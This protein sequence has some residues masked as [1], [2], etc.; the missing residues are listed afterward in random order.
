MTVSRRPDRGKPT[1]IA[2]PEQAVRQ[3][4]S[5]IDRAGAEQ[6]P[7]QRLGRDRG[8]VEEE[9]GEEP[10]LRP[11]WWAASAASLVRAAT[12]AATNATKRRR[13]QAE[14]AGGRGWR[15]IR[16]TRE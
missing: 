15:R 16:C 6:A 1:Q 3:R 10:D 5:D 13:A 2:R 14:I 12:D 11:V 4:M 9:R 7:D 8:R